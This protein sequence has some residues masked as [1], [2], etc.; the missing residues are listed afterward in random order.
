MNFFIFNIGINYD[1][2][3]YNCKNNPKYYLSF[4]KHINFFYNFTK[5]I[6]YN[7]K[8]NENQRYQSFQL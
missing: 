2:N 6:F 7:F 3:K 4:T 1:R 8:N 5:L